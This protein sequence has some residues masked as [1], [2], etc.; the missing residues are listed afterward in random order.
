MERE[1]PEKWEKDQGR[2]ETGGENFEEEWVVS[3]IN[4]LEIF[5]FQIKEAHHISKNGILF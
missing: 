1:K 5:F 2:Q 4:A 3:S